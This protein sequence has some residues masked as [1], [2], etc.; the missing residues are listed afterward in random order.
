M[1]TEVCAHGFD[2]TPAIETHV[3]RQLAINLANFVSHIVSVEVFLSDIN[4][5]KGGP[6][7]KALICVRLG[8][9]L[10]VKVERTRRDLYLAV[11]GAARQAK[12]AVKR[13]LNRHR[14][15]ER[16]ALRQL[17]QVW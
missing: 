13:T 16:L 6:D 14:R 10:T 17:R 2:M 3:R 5:P 8:S 11:T 9:R 4:G 12:R 15:M 1:K 7:K